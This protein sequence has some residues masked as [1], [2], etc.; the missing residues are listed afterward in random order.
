M[1]DKIPEKGTDVA[2]VGD[3]KPTQFGFRKDDYWSK[4]HMLPAEHR[5][6]DTSK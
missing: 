4:R 3:Y 1:E 2:L 5:L 6:D